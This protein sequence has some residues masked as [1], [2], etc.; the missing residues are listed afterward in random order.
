MRGLVWSLLPSVLK[1]RLCRRI[2]VTGAE[3]TGTTTLALDLSAALG[4][5]Y[6][7]EYG[8]TYTE[9]R[10]DVADNPWR[11]EELVHIA[12]KQIELENTVARTSNTSCLIADTDAFTTALWHERYFGIRSPRVDAIAERQVRPFAYILTGDEIPFEADTIREGGDARHAMHERF[13]EDIT[14]TNVPFLEVSG[15]PD[16]RL[17]QALG[18]LK[19]LGVAP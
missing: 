7:P 17:N 9:E 8:R 18:F 13:R 2:V 6:V 16:I 19:H 15:H 1:A 11:E 12:E 10:A 14:Q 5:P 4:C 3:S